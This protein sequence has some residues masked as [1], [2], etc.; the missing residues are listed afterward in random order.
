VRWH[1]R[2]FVVFALVVGCANPPP[3][4]SDR[5]LDGVADD[6]DA[7]PTVPGVAATTPQTRGC[8]PPRV[9]MDADGIPDDEDPCPRDPGLGSRF[10][11]ARRGCWSGPPDRDGDGIPDPDDR[12]P[13]IRGDRT[14][15]ATTNGCPLPSD[16]DHDG[17]ADL[18]DACPDVPGKR[19]RNEKTTGCPPAAKD[20]RVEGDRIVLDEV[21][22]FDNDSPRVRHAS[23]PLLKNVAAFLGAT[24]DIETIEVAG[25]SD[26][27]GDADHNLRLSRD[28][29]N[30][31]RSLLVRFG[32]DPKRMTARA[33]GED[34]P[35]RPGES[36]DALKE[37]RRVE[38]VI[39]SA[40]LGD[41]DLHTT[42]GPLP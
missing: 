9:D 4:R 25:Y 7:C 41:V 10:G 36:E 16:R 23:W 2:T 34:R 15:S 24:P 39:T 3:V 35:H 5:D 18:D 29:A 31:V 12:C 17:I 20:I 19:T 42:A 26:A 28:R 6:E 8:P 21:I 1:I 30:A 40:R 38:L 32:V 27:A 33:Y 37:N 22:H 14:W 13:D 11:D